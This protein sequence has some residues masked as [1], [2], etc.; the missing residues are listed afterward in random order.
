MEID[1]PHTFKILL[2][3]FNLKEINW[4]HE[5]SYANEDHISW[6]FLELCRDNFLVQ[7]VKQHTRIREGSTPSTLDL[8]FTNLH[9]IVNDVLYLPP[10]GSSDHL[11]ISFNL[12]VYSFKDMTTRKK[13]LYFKGE[14]ELIKQQIENINWEIELEEQ[15]MENAWNNFMSKITNIIKENVPERIAS[16]NSKYYQ[17][18]WMNQEAKMAIKNKRKLWRNFIYCPN[19]YNRYRYKLARN[20]AA[21]QVK[22]ARKT[23]ELSIAANIKK[24]SKSFWRYVKSKTKVKETIPNLKHNG[25]T[26]DTEIDKATLLNNYFT[27]V[28]TV[29]SALDQPSLDDRNFITVLDD[30]D[31]KKEEIQKFLEKIN[32][33]KSPGNDNLHPKFL[34]ETAKEISQPLSI[35]CRLSLDQSVIPAQWK[36]A[37]ISAIHKKGN[38]DTPSNYRPI[39]LTSLA[40]KTMEKLL[41]DQLVKHMNSNKLFTEHQHGFR[42]GYS[43]ATQLI[44]VLDN[45][46]S[47]LDNKIDTDVVYLDFQKAF[48]TVPHKRLLTKLNAYGIRGK[49]FNW[50]KEFLTNRKQRVVLNGQNSCW[51][52]VTSGIPQGTVLGPILFLIYINDLPEAVE[53]AVKLFA[54]DTKLYG[55]VNNLSDE[56]KMQQDITK[57][58]NWSDKWLLKFN[59]DKCKHMHIGKNYHATSYS[60]D[61]KEISKTNCERDLGVMIDDQLKFQQH[62]NT[63]VKKANQKLGIIKRNFNHLDKNSFVSLYKALVRPHLEYAS[64]VWSTIFKKDAIAI[65]NTQRRATKILRGISNLTYPERL[66]YLGLP[67]LEYR[68]IRSDMIQVYKFLNNIDKMDDDLLKINEN[69]RTRGHNKKLLKSHSR[70]NVRKFSFTERVVNTWNNLPSDV[71]NSKNINLFKSQLNKHWKNQEIKFNPACLISYS[72]PELVQRLSHRTRTDLESRETNG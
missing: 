67:S 62:I 11:T 39:S 27:S 61:G 44:G 34:K 48:D 55:Q 31:I 6:K 22:V 35:L 49:V 20:E 16:A 25:V 69:S 40:C 24:D 23:Y 38:K 42:S 36:Q 46:T 58:T 47:N 41:R 3:D 7:H 15:S 19:T 32:P 28:F 70:L 54:D 1:I 45:W 50:I 71:I 29:E 13:F 63:A 14:Y 37:N 43:C 53:N 33:S 60:M 4:E 17:T 56:I 18:P 30:I 5:Y 12:N 26:M 64:S 66:K 65:E 51:T 10:L 52:D 9:Y 57:L 72:Q 59:A 8:I 2:G 21:Y 68:R